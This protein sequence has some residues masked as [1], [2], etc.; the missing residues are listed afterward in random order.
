MSLALALAPSGRLF[1]EDSDEASLIPG[2]EAAERIRRAFG[3]GNSSGLLHLATVEL[4][5]DLAPGL[6]FWRDF[7][8]M[9]LTQLCHTQ[10]AES[11]AQPVAAPARAEMDAMVGSAP[12][13]T[14]LEYL[15]AAVLETLWHG[16]DGA[17][18]NEMR[19]FPGGAPAYLRAKNPI[20]N[21][22][23]RV[24][25]HL[26]ENKR[27]PDNPFAFL[28]TYSSRVSKQA[29]LQYLPL[30]KALEE[31]A[32]AQNR[33]ALLS[34]LSPVQRASEKSSLVRE[35]VA[36]GDVFRPLAWRPE[37]AY[38]FLQEIP[39]VEESGI[40]VR[41]PDWWKSGRPQRPVVNV[42]IGDRNA[43]KIGWDAL[44]DFSVSL[45]LDGEPLTD[46]EWQSILNST[47]GLLLLKGKW[48]EVD[49]DKLSQVL[50]QWKEVEIQHRRHGISFLE[51]MRLL[52]GAGLTASDQFIARE[53]RAT[54]PP[55]P[56]AIGCTRS[57]ANCAIRTSS[58]NATLAAIC[59]QNCA[60]TRKWESAG[61]GL[62][63]AWGWAHAWPM[64]WD[65]GKRSR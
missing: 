52:A 26:A 35:L 23:G 27:D 12:P 20:W 56:R 53:T 24:F 44:L 50:Q 19:E 65:L 8:R 32:G 51:G 57:C 55:L 31:Y 54:G 16:L 11:G 29:R 59:R 1:V 40:L 37:E 15:N 47:Q 60:H 42:R 17:V 38:R 43:R 34:L 61:C 10:G 63:T 64:T 62:C 14:G 30:G 58:R 36:S 41:V 48:V 5:T 6:S 46:A 7:G 25:F 9:Y 49:R 21:L 45:T 4:G 33:N 22:V 3:E 28:A 18:R 13:M 39:I 2:S